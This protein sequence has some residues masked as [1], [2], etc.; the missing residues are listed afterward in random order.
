MKKGN[1][2]MH[3]FYKIT[4]LVWAIHNLHLC[5][6]E[7]QKFVYYHYHFVSIRHFMTSFS[8]SFWR[9]WRKRCH[10]MSN[11][12]KMIMIINKLIKFPSPWKNKVVQKVRNLQNFIWN[13]N[14]FTSF[15][16]FWTFRSFHYIYLIWHETF[17]FLFS[18]CDCRLIPSEH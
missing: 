17:T 11:A 13:Q 12:D 10:E 16:Q 3:R 18:P 14:T 5:S 9:T 1:T 8:P 15:R 7:L 2:T 4:P 6:M